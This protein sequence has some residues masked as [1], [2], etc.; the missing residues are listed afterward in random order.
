MVL[1]ADPPLRLIE[2]LSSEWVMAADLLGISK[3]RTKIIR[4]DNRGTSIVNCCREVMTLWLCDDDSPNYP[5]SWD[6]V[7]KLL[8]D[9]NLKGVANRLQEVIESRTTV[10]IK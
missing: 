10:N 3:V 8:R 6:G 2:T 4:E 7:C 1:E 9:M 5:R